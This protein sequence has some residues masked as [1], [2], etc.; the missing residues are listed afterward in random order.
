MKRVHSSLLEVNLGVDVGQL[1]L[2]PL[3][4]GLGV[5]D[6]RLEQVGVILGARARGGGVH[7]NEQNVSIGSS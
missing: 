5:V 2:E 7:C 3:D 1:P 6:V 4:P